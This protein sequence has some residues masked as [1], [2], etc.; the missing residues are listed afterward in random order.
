MH[1][2]IILRSVREKSVSLVLKPVNTLTL[3]CIGLNNV[4]VAFIRYSCLYTNMQDYI[5]CLIN[6]SE[7]KVVHPNIYEAIYVSYNA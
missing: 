1:K 2:A 6:I 5:I 7:V 4:G 3:I